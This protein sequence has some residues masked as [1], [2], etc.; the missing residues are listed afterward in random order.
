MS[1]LENQQAV[2]EAAAPIEEVA[3]TPEIDEVGQ[4]P[5]EAVLVIEEEAVLVVEEEAVLV[6]EEEAVLVIEE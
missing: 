3:P 1:E 4:D 2:S 6:I 5:E